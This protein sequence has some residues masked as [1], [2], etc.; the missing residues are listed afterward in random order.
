MYTHPDNSLNARMYNDIR[1]NGAVYRDTYLTITQHTSS[2]LA[3][4]NLL[5]T[6]FKPVSNTTTKFSLSRVLSNYLVSVNTVTANLLGV[7]VFRSSINQHNYSDGT[8]CAYRYISNVLDNSIAYTGSSLITKIIFKS[9]IIQRNSTSSCVAF[10][11]VFGCYLESVS[12]T[13]VTSVVAA[14]YATCLRIALHF[15]LKDY[16]GDSWFG[17]AISTH[18]C[19]SVIPTE[20]IKV[21]A[22]VPPSI[23]LLEEPTIESG[24]VE[25]QTCVNRGTP[26]GTQI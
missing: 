2:S 10:L 13:A 6:L 25:R 9:L 8:M 19:D 24:Y 18:T 17:C 15:K 23:M 3:V 20:D 7:C 14:I 11:K 4:K 21:C 1:V 16:V 26:E 22:S 5:R 12:N